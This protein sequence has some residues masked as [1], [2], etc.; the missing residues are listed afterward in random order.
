[1]A[2]KNINCEWKKSQTKSLTPGLQEYKL[3]VA[4][5]KC[6]KGRFVELRNDLILLNINS[7][8]NEVS[9]CN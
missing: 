7:L 4:K 8:E 6:I 5:Q 2:R 9:K 3:W 1:M